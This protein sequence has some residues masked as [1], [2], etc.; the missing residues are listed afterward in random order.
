MFNVN[1]K[2]AGNRLYMQLTIKT[3]DNQPDVHST[4]IDR[5]GRPIYN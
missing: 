3:Y 4:S 2:L 1:L 5:K